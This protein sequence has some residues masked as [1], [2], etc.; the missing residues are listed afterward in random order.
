MAR[1]HFRDLDDINFSDEPPRTPDWLN[2]LLTI[3][4][5]VA[6]AVAIVAFW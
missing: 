3:S 5:L 1:G 6:S 4:M 2:G